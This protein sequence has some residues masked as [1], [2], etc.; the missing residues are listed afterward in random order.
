M[1]GINWYR[2]V[3]HHLESKVKRHYHELVKN[4]LPPN[5]TPLEHFTLETK[6][7]YKNK[8]SD[9]RNVVPIIEKYFLDGLQQHNVVT[10]D[11][12]INDLGGSWKVVEQSKDN[13][14]CEITLIP[15]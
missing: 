11:T 7:Y 10:N 2:N 12:V 13:P 5:V 8:A 9:G 6:L 14:R 15:L 4:Q 3:H 1:V